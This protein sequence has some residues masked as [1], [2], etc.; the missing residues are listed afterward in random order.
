MSSHDSLKRLFDPTSIAIVGASASP[1]KA[2]YQ[3][4][5]NLH[6]FRGE[7]VPINPKADSI[8]GHRAYPSLKAVERPIDL[9]VLAVPAAACVEALAEAVDTG[10]GAA[11][12]VGGGFAEA[13]GAGEVLQAD[14]AR[15]V[16]RGPTRLLGP[17]TAGFA[18]PVRGFSACFAPGL[19]RL[20][21]GK[22]AVVAQ[23]AGVAL[24]A[25]FTAHDR[26]HGLRLVAGLGNA[27][28]IN[29]ADMLDFLADDEE[30]AAIALHLEGVPNGRPLVEAARRLTARKP[31]V[32]LTVGRSDIGAFAASHTGN[33]IGGYDLR[34]AALRQA[35][36]VVVDCIGDLVDATAALATVRLP[37]RARPGVGIVTGQAGPGLLMLDLL[38]GHGVDVPPLQE[39]TAARIAALL[40][41]M[42]YMANPVDT[43][44][45]SASFGGV[46][47]AVSGDPGVHLTL[48]YALHEPA[49]V[50]PTEALAGIGGRD[51]RPVVFGTMGL[52]EDIQPTL[53]AL[54]AAGVPAYAS[55]EA[56][57]GA[58][59]ALVEDS[60]ARVG[61]ER[62]TASPAGT[63]VAASASWAPPWD[64]AR[65]K[66][67]LA[68][69]GIA[70]PLSFVCRTRQDAEA[71][72]A[73]IGG[74][75]VVKV[76]NDAIVHKTE[77]GG[78]H[79]GVDSLSRL[80]AAIDAID[81]IPVATRS[82][83][84]VEEMVPDGVELIVGAIADA[85]FGPTVMVG[86]GGIDAE[87]QRDRAVRLA[88]LSHDEAVGMLRALRCFP[89]LTGWRGRPG[90]DI[91]TL[92]SI[93][94]RLADLIAADSRI[95][96]IEINPL[97]VLPDRA[98]ALD[99]LLVPRVG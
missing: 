76:L 90:A 80:H 33:M 31:L 13:G 52:R 81:A 8:L 5:R 28:D 66:A 37:A 21:S 93:I 95:A 86:A 29:A 53:E 56:A 43:G 45:P 65:A 60:R 42:T 91:D 83:Y 55:P 36:A 30:T 3:L 82:R 39:M 92:A 49:A 57:A 87:L 32:V 50:Q 77:V 44:R 4:I 98:V 17:N 38:K 16:A 35:G 40:P 79:L 75:A 6:G 73:R 62:S 19:D 2:G 9:V 12:I 63:P 94:R 72:F 84:L 34:V 22:I 14:L 67:L 89:K 11:M 23:S 68:A 64:E 54:W 88:P 7:I 71:A 99:A 41:G 58:V 48:V 61:G 10:A 24:T 47:S 78:V 74:R 15:I 97:R 25:G 1:D 26:G 51:G 20:R 85:S 18:N 69:A 27:V 96:E 70:T 46:I 59:R